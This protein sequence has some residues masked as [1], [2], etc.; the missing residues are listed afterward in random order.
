MLM[1]GSALKGLLADTPVVAAVK[2]DAGLKKCLESEVDVVF[3]LYGDVVTISD[4]VDQIKSAGKLAMVHIDLIHGLKSSEVAVDFIKKYTRA[5]GIIST[6]TPVILHARQLGLHTV[7]RFFVLDSMALSS[8]EK[9]VKNAR[10]EVVEIMPS[11]MP[12]KVKKICGMVK[13]PVIVGGLVSDRDDVEELLSAG[14]TSISAS[15][16]D[17]WVM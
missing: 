14:A 17:L 8:M 9:Q 5:D 11:L 15:N 12:A 6:K 13:Q 10:P 16:P 2:D 7:M 3:V 1:G 4:I